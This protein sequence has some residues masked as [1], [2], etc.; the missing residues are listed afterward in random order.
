MVPRCKSTVAFFTGPSDSDDDVERRRPF[1][2]RAGERLRHFWL[3]D[4]PPDDER[5]CERPMDAYRIVSKNSL[6]PYA[7]DQ[8]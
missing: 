3:F 6:M 7:L 1:P 2:D 5:R 4:E 8:C